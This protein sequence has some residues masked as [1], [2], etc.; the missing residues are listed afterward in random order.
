[1]GLEGG[2][3]SDGMRQNSIQEQEEVLRLGRK[4]N[5]AE[6][7]PDWPGFIDKMLSSL[8]KLTVLISCTHAPVHVVS[9]AY[10]VYLFPDFW[11]L[12]NFYM[13][14]RISP[15]DTDSTVMQQHVIYHET[16]L[17]YFRKIAPLIIKGHSKQAPLRTALGTGYVIGG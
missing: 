2:E 4:H 12:E 9:L 3:A 16:H 13:I 15:T 10:Y 7:R 11:S 5:G 17:H 14:Y 8:F 1:M 6:R